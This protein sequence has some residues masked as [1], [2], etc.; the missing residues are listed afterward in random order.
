MPFASSYVYLLRR[1]HLIAEPM[2]ACATWQAACGRVIE[3]LGLQPRAATQALASVGA[4]RAGAGGGL[5]RN[6]GLRV[7]QVR[8]AQELDSVALHVCQLRG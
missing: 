3:Y 6:D 1:V 2:L 8:V 7:Q 4:E 5:R